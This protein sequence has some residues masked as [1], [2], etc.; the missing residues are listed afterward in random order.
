MLTQQGWH[1]TAVVRMRLYTCSCK[2]QGIMNVVRLVA[3]T[4]RRQTSIFRHGMTYYP[5]SVLIVVYY[6]FP[7][8]STTAQ[9]LIADPETEP[10]KYQI[11]RLA[12][13]NLSPGTNTTTD[14]K[15]HGMNKQ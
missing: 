9:P 8:A 7:S 15:I 12:I 2:K 14:E 10:Y 6:M 3:D 4:V 11:Q 13:Y 1:V 5:A